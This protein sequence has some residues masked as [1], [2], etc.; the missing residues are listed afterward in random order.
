MKTAKP[1]AEAKTPGTLAV[2]KHR[3]LMNKLTTA[4]RRR[5]RRRAA[6][7]VYGREA[8]APAR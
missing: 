4:E 3:P 5:L 8:V 7:L 1:A 2:E 6:E